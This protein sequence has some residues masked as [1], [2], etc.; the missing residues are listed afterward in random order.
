MQTAMFKLADIYLT[1][2][3][4]RQCMHSS[5]ASSAVSAGELRRALRTAAGEF[6][7]RA[8]RAFPRCTR[9]R[10]R[11]GR[12]GRRS[13]RPRRRGRRAPGTRT[14]RSVAISG[15]PDIWSTPD[16]GGVAFQ[17]DVGAESLEFVHM[18]EAVLEHVLGDRAGAFGHRVQRRELG[19]HVGRKRRVRRGRDIDRLGRRPCML[20]SI[21]SSVVL[22]SAPA[23]SSFCRTESSVSARAWPARGRR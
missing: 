15:A 14:R 21:E 6:F 16:H 22:I 8:C 5:C 10:D 23:S 3:A 20:I 12:C 11:C 18:H 9:N 4:C 1:I 7:A 19:L 2:S 17:M 13:C